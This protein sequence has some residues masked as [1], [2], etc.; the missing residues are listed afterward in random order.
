MNPGTLCIFG[1]KL[2]GLERSIP[3]AFVY[4]VPCE[5]LHEAI[6]QAGSPGKEMIGGADQGVV[7]AHLSWEFNVV[8][9]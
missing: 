8:R 6:D 4:C 3:G 5:L 7:A 9:S 1:A 2:A